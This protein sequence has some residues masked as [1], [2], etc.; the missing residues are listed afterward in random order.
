MTVLVA[1]LSHWRRHPLQLA[2]LVIGLAVATALWSGVQAINAEARAA[3]AKAAAVLGQD[4][5]DRLVPV[6]GVLAP[7]D[8]AGLRRG[9]W[10]V[11][12][13]LEGRTRQ[14]L[15]VLGIEPLTLPREAAIRGL[16]GP[17]EGDFQDFLTGQ[18]VLAAP[19]T[20][21]R[22]GVAAA[23]RGL[24]PL[25]APDLPPMTVLADIGLAERM[26]ERQGEITALLIDPARP[27]PGP[28]P[29]GLELRTAAPDDG[30]ARLTDS[31]HLNLTAFGVLA[32]AVG[33]FIVHSAIGLAFEQ[34]RP[35][36]RTLRA[37]GVPARALGALILTELLTLALIAGGVGIALGYLLAAALLP[38]VAATLGGLYGA[39]V[40]GA[41]ALRPGWVAGGLAMAVAG[42]LAAGAGGTWQ[43]FRLPPLATAQSQAHAG[44]ATALRRAQ[45]LAGM[46][47]LA[48]AG[49]MLMAGQGLWAGFAV[50]AALLLGAA[51]LLPAALAGLLRLGV[52]LARG[53]LAEWFWADTR[54]Q[55]PGLSLAL[56]A[57]LLAL[58]ANVGVGTMVA[59]FRSTFTGWLDQRLASE[60]YLTVET[61]AQAVEIRAWLEPQVDAM[62][63]IVE[64]E[65]R[66]AGQP[67]E[68]Y[69][70]ADHA[71]YRDHW[72]L[73]TAIPEVWDQVARG[74]GVL[75]NEQLY[76]RARLA[77]GDPL[78][79]PGGDLPVVGVYSDYGNPSPQ[80]ILGL[81][82]F[83]TRFPQAET[84]RFALRL[85]PEDVA[86]LSAALRAEFGL[87]ETAL[88][89]Q[90]GLKAF[91][92][93]IFER[94]F[95]VT[96][97]LNTL[98]LGVA[99]IAMLASLLTLA[100]QRLVQLAP[101]WALGLTQA[102]LARLDLGRTLLL[103]LM[104]AILSL[105]LG[106]ALAWVLL[107]VVNVEAFGWRL[108]MQV[109]PADWLWLAAAAFMAAVLAGLLPALRLMR[110]QPSDLLRIFA[111][112]R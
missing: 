94:T 23:L 96:G 59:S 41:L 35:M 42:T 69:G 52:R 86:A 37:L 112:E 80:A 83:Q 25:P 10:P 65:A 30:L 81:T 8:Y 48:T 82:S 73:L 50:L 13:V 6:S 45:A 51:L 43:A 75:V 21:D 20:L 58:S 22:P 44:S 100:D 7:A 31:F 98:T 55:L 63:P 28:I 56:M 103:A 33:I 68:I 11:S 9:G 57:L 26:L 32:F 5:M 29:A 49:V 109:F 39:T 102:R 19:E 108:P 46:A 99:A 101:V 1:L 38:D 53:P 47:L 72:P 74:E 3:Y 62:L 64:A 85:P 92:L 88:V 106:L 16:P 79:L 4:R 95:A 77:L 66:L 90:A 105:P 18:V 61:P 40:P 71:T 70:V 17:A 14:G 15:R 107:A 34:R 87:V 84:R 104:T 67:G 27:L 78:P 97:A 76:R 91:S 89:D 93:R 54:H 110:R 24:E 111:H 2:M 12:P 60:L 36:L